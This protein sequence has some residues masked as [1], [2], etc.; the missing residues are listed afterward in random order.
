MFALSTIG[1]AFALYLA[2]ASYIQLK[3]FC[4]LCAAT[5]VA[6]IALFIISG[7]AT[8]FPMTTLP[9]RAPRDLRTLLSSPVALVLALLYVVGAGSLIAY[10]PSET[11]QASQ[12]APAPAVRRSPINSAPSSS[13]GG[14]SSR[15]WICR[16]RL[17]VPR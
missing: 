9:R 13:S 17:T 16:S 14:T 10:F 5:Y 15:A 6:V 12:Q 1:L 7:G 11:P 3:T 2:W 4:M 8:T